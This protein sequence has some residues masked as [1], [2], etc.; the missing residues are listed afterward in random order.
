MERFSLWRYNK[1]FL[2]TENNTNY[3]K[4]ISSISDIT[5]SEYILNNNINN[6][7]NKINEIKSEL[8][9]ELNKGNLPNILKKMSVIQYFI[10]T[11]KK[12]IKISIQ[13]PSLPLYSVMYEN[14][15]Y[16]YNNYNY[17]RL[18]S[19]T[20]NYFYEKL[21]NSWFYSDFEKLLDY[22]ILKK[23]FLILIK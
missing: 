20:T 1:I 17:Y 5:L 3:I 9:N 7:N 8:I 10:T 19:Y 2:Y 4:I 23:N 12:D 16:S 15:N 13:S 14:S 21:Y 18:L 6:V 22:I 11:D